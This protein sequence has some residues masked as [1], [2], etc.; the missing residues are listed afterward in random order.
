MCSYIRVPV[1]V[2]LLVRYLYSCIAPITRQPG[3]RLAEEVHWE[4]AHTLFNF[5]PRAAC[6]SPLDCA[7]ALERANPNDWESGLRQSREREGVYFEQLLDDS[8]YHSDM[9]ERPYRYFRELEYGA[10]QQQRPTSRTDFLALVLKHCGLPNPT[11]TELRMFLSFLNV[12]LSDCEQ[13]VFILGAREDLPGLQQFLI[14]FLLEMSRDF[15]TRSLQLAEQ[16]LN[17]CSRQKQQRSQLLPVSLFQT[18]RTCCRA[19]KSS[20]IGNG[21]VIPMCCS[22]GTAIP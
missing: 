13:N 9:Y 18:L 11:W 19:S 5:L 3:Q 7:R 1:L 15:A 21:R 10:P 6:C 2:V 12:Q 22:T 4:A 8:L 20:A 17:N 14:K 16:T